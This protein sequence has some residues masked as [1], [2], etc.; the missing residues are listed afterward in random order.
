MIFA[1]YTIAKGF[2]V[3]KL[4]FE[5]SSDEQRVRKS[6]PA[7]PGPSI[8]VT[9]DIKGEVRRNFLIG[10]KLLSEK[11]NRKDPKLVKIY[12]IRPKRSI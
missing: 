4:E 6:S 3:P 2:S 1:I 9:A 11:S 5:F 10:L 12:Q 8:A 7:A